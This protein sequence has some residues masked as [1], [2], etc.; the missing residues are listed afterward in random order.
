M[1][2]SVFLYVFY[3]LTGDPVV[4]PHPCGR[5]LEM[6]IKCAIFYPCGKVKLNVTDYTNQLSV[7]SNDTHL[8]RL[9]GFH[10]GF[11]VRYSQLCHIF[12]HLVVRHLPRHNWTVVAQQKTEQ[13]K[14]GKLDFFTVVG[15]ELALNQDDLDE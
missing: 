8:Q 4:A 11:P 12:H 13:V 15:N 14:F 9:V 2:F 10:A 7:H 6:A 3:E 5:L 1:L